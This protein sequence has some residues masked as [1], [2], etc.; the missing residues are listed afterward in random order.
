MDGACLIDEERT[1]NTLVVIVD[2]Q[3]LVG[4]VLRVPEFVSGR[5]EA[6]EYAAGGELSQCLVEALGDLLLSRFG[7]AANPGG[8]GFRLENADGNKLSAAGA[9]ACLA[10]Y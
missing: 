6:F 3:A 4:F 2:G 9:A 10:G 5:D 7:Q 1:G 8:E